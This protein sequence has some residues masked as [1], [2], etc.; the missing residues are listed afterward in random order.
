MSDESVHLLQQLIKAKCVNDGTTDNG[1]GFRVFGGTEH[2]FGKFGI[3][4]AAY[5]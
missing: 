2:A 3:E 5:G 1:I 4:A